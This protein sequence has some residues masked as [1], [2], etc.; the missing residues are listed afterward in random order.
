MTAPTQGKEWGA[1]SA[2]RGPFPRASSPFPSLLSRRR[3]L[4]AP[5]RTRPPAPCAGAR[6]PLPTC[7]IGT[8]SS[9]DRALPARPAPGSPARGGL[10]NAGGRED[11][12]SSRAGGGEEEDGAF[13]GATAPSRAAPASGD[14]LGEAA[15]VFAPSDPGSTASQGYPRG[16]SEE[17]GRDPAPQGSEGKK[18][19]LWVRRLRG[20]LGSGPLWGR[21]VKDLRGRKARGQSQGTRSEF[22][23]KAPRGSPARGGVCV[24]A[25]V[26]VCPRVSACV[27]KVDKG[28]R[29]PRGRCEGTSRF[30]SV[31]GGDLVPETGKLNWRGVH[32]R[33][34]LSC[35]RS[36]FIS[37]NCFLS[38]PFL[39][40]F[41]RLVAHAMSR[42]RLCTGCSLDL[43]AV[44]VRWLPHPGKA[45]KPWRPRDREPSQTSFMLMNAHWGR[46]YREGAGV[47]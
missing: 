42:Y 2:P 41:L 22:S 47:G 14:P 12:K 45:R 11:P 23:P 37:P 20:S 9:P 21:E 16:W 28:V 6:Q 18:D 29:L 39:F 27:C 44:A 24:C 36:H 10:A 13:L 7:E 5:R 40:S 15:G 35:A 3:S 31:R 34:Q 30:S 33:P 19:E 43:N 4:R 32:G 46:T 38:F 25:H 1:A 26:C 8:S 17:G